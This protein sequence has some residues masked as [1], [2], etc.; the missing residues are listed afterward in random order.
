MHDPPGYSSIQEIALDRHTRQKS[1]I[2]QSI[3]NFIDFDRGLLPGVTTTFK[4]GYIGKVRDRV[5]Y[6]NGWAGI[7]GLTNRVYQ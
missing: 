6:S 2:L 1:E 3:M 4:T 5:Y 7:L